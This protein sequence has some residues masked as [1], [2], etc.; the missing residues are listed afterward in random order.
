MNNFPADIMSSQARG[1]VVGVDVVAGTPFFAKATDLEEKSLLWR[2]RNRAGVVPGIGSVLVRSAT[3]GSEA[4]TVLSRSK[5]EV[6][7]QP[8]LDGIERL[9]F[10]SLDA[11][12][13][14]GYRATSEAIDRIETRLK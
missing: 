12:V 6:L 3:V 9:S 11:A 10:Q 14:F 1:V 7:I 4:Q 5:V 13:E 2:L 8:R